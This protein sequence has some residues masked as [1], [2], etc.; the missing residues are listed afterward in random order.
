MLKDYLKS[1]AQGYA[2]AY[3]ATSAFESIQ[4]R[5][6]RIE[7]QAMAEDRIKDELFR[8]GDAIEEALDAQN[9]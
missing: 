5:K 1:F 8:L 9:D 4:A 2:I 6:A 3:L 7:R